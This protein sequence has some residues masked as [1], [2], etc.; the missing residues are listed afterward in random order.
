MAK[1]AFSKLNKVKTWE[2]KVVSFNGN[3]MV[4]K[5]YIP[6]E[7]KVKLITAIIEQSGDE[8]GFF[9]I[10]KLEAFYRI[11]MVKAYTNISFTE[12]QLEDPTKI[13]D[14]LILNDIWSFVEKQIPQVERDY[15]WS[16]VLELAREITTY[17]SSV[18]GILRQVSAE[19]ETMNLD[20]LN[21]QQILKDPE[22]L[23]LIKTVVTKL[24]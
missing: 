18:L 24:G 7:T 2:D 22:S 16:N 11:E 9:N 4:I 23:E 10:I 8:A 3:E 17:H 21:I 1:L 19:Y 5:Q 13:Y 12:K 14:A 6:L 15:I 20:A